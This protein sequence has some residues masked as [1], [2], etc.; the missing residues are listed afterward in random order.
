MRAI[1]LALLII[2][3]MAPAWAQSTNSQSAFG[4]RTQEQ[5]DNDVTITRAAQLI[6]CYRAAAITNAYAEND[7][8][9]QNAIELC[10]LIYSKY[11]STDP[12]VK[13]DV[14]KEAEMM[15]DDCYLAVARILR[16]PTVCTYMSSQKTSSS[17]PDT[18]LFGTKVS[19]DICTEE[20]TNLANL[21]PDKYYSNP[22]NSN[23]CEMVFILPVLV[24]GALKYRN[25]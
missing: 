11:Q 5:C 12:T 2:L 3:F 10:G 13:S 25:S 23:L 14:P 9:R 24:V 20:A 18:G 21:A 6:N 1:F 17:S 16:D 8:G 4:L 15:S 22:N 7:V 19:Q